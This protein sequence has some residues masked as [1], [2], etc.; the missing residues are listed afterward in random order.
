MEQSE[1]YRDSFYRFNNAALDEMQALTESEYREN[2]LVR[3]SNTHQQLDEALGEVEPEEY[4]LWGIIMGSPGGR[5][6]AS[7]LDPAKVY[8]VG[9]AL[10]VCKRERQ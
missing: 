2:T 8:P 6:V 5:W 7:Q 4:E 3:L 10:Y 1:E 9:T